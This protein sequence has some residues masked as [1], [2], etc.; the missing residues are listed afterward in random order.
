ME[1]FHHAHEAYDIPSLLN[2]SYGKPPAA[3]IFSLFAG[4]K[5]EA[6]SSSR[7]AAKILED[8]GI[9]VV[10]KS[11]HPGF[12]S[13]DLLRQAAEAHHFGMSWEGALSAV[14]TV[15][16]RRMGLDHRIGCE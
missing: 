15:P 12:D 5:R 13:R 16:A 3:A 7:F 6:Y 9:D 8:S 10:I 1:A 2:S 14:S 11:D 4:Y